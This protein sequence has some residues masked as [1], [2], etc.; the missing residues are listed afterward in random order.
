MA[1]PVGA[2]G[3][4]NKEGGVQLE[5][6]AAGVSQSA[7]RRVL[8]QLIAQPAHEF[9]NDHKPSATRPIGFIVANAN[10]PRQSD[11]DKSVREFHADSAEYVSSSFPH[12]AH[13]HETVP[14]C[15][16]FFS[17]NPT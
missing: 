2:Q 1:Q 13:S 5:R 8:E 12:R 10:F 4:P 9:D 6:I 14:V 7:R 17:P 15:H 11:I 3:L 16:E